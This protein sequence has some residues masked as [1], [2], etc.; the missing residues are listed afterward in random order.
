[1]IAPR[2]DGAQPIGRRQ[3]TEEM[4]SRTAASQR[5]AMQAAMTAAVL[6]MRS[7]GRR[8]G[9]RDPQDAPRGGRA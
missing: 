7:S 4:P 8:P 9:R 3:D 2:D 6:A 5:R 1:V